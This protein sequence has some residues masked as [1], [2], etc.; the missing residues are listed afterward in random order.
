MACHSGVNGTTIEFWNQYYTSE[1]PGKKLVGSSWWRTH[2][3]LLCEFKSL[4]SCKAGNGT[5]IEIW[6]DKGED[7]PL[8]QL[9]PQ[10]FSHARKEK[11][12]LS[13][14]IQTEELQNQFHTPLSEQAFEQFNEISVTL[15]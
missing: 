8:Q 13:E 6:N 7:R 2:L 14:M 3:K 1:L 12:T 4:A 5:T 9:Y 11:V 15:Q 10:L